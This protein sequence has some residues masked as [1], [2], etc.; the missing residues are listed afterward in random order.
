M[1]D[2]LADARPR[3]EEAL[4][5]AVAQHEAAHA[6]S[7]IE[8]VRTHP[9]LNRPRLLAF[10]KVVIRRGQGPDYLGSDGISKPIW[11]E[12]IG[13]LPLY[14]PSESRD[15]V[16]RMQPQRRKEF[17]EGLILPKVVM[18]L[19]GPLSLSLNIAHHRRERY[20]RYVRSDSGNFSDYAEAKKL[21]P[22]LRMAGL[23]YA[24]LPIEHCTYVLLLQMRRLIERVGAKL[25]EVGELNHDDVCRLIDESQTGIRRLDE[26]L[27]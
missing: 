23:P 16:R 18:L 13:G 10:E 21:L 25:F 7:L 11:G 1:S 17:A 26:L 3:D 4:W 19:S 27:S 6:V 24:L 2:G 8:A 20:F 14:E 22:D 9:K 15:L 5:R 12:V